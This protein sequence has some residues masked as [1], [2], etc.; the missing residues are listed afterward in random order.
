MGLR[1][2]PCCFSARLLTAVNVGNGTQERF[3][4]A[5]A[6][7]YK[8]PIA[9]PNERRPGGGGE[10]S[11]LQFAVSTLFSPEPGGRECSACAMSVER[12]KVMHAHEAFVGCVCFRRAVQTPIQGKNSP[13]TRT[14][15]RRERGEQ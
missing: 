12:H 15:R 5:F 1:F 9:S 11:L 3:R 4:E 14:H 6:A 10:K 8:V 7:R 13:E 2:H